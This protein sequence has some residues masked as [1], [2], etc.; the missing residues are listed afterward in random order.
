MDYT[1]YGII[2][3]IILGWVAFPFSR[4]IF[5][6]QGSNPGLPH[7]RRILYQLSHKGSQ[8][9]LECIA[10][11]FS[12]GSSRPRDQ[13]RVSCIGGGFFT[14][15]AIRGAL[16]RVEGESS[17]NRCYKC[18]C[19]ISE[20]F[21]DETMK[22]IGLDNSIKGNLLETIHEY[23]ILSTT[24]ESQAQEMDAAVLFRKSQPT[25][26]RQKWE[27]AVISRLYTCSSGKFKR[28]YW[29]VLIPRRQSKKGTC[30]GSPVVKT[31]CFQCRGSRGLMPGWGTKIVHAT[32]YGPK[33]RTL[34]N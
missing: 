27:K 24:F 19:W 17:L 15:W 26:L 33:K 9:I 4:G 10:C 5:P 32:W 12:S 11:P 6:T 30:L 14:N 20:F 16:Y 2:Q 28:I 1:V 3:P 8:R 21:A 34:K 31:P 22:K 23:Y 25:W 13:T 7:C 18:L 29:Q